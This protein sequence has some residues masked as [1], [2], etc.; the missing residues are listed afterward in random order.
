MPNYKYHLQ[1][2]S[3]TSKRTCPKCGKSKC[4]TLYLDAE[5]RPV[6]NEF[7][8]C[9]HAGCGYFRYPSADTSPTT[10]APIVTTQQPPQ[11]YTKAE[12]QK[13]RAFEMDNTLSQYLANK[14]LDIDRL[15]SVFRDYCIG[16]VENGIIFWQIDETFKIHRGKVMWYKDNGHRMKLTR[17]DG[18][19]YGKVQMMW[20]YLNHDRERE[21][22]MCYFGQHLVS[23]Y[24]DKPLA[25]VES[26]KTAI[27]MSY[28]YPE[29]VWLATLSLNNFQTYRMNFL[30]EIRRPITI[31]PD[32]DGT[33]QWE[34][35]TAAIRE[36]MPGIKIA[37]NPFTHIFGEGK[38]DL[39]D[40]AFE[41]F[42]AGD[43]TFIDNFIQ[44]S[45][46]YK[47]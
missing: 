45:K 18:S 3:R 9:D 5:D 19:E 47:P 36:L 10:A 2:Y 37:V 26:E 13:Y 33:D 44:Y 28:I 29:F 15:K 20:K 4:F 38:Q 30:R 41:G 11:Y 22:E 39:A 42:F 6:G 25:I 46:L 21:P 16:S 23:I 35:K 14:F 24:N 17:T 31:F 40:I 8:R 43:S 12:V 34:Q 27:I 32:C 7:G 1:P